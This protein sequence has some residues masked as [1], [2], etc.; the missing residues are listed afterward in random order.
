MCN[1]AVTPLLVGSDA[2]GDEVR[3]TF[4]EMKEVFEKQTFLRIT[5]DCWISPYQKYV[6]GATAHWFN[7][8]FELQEVI[9]C[10]KEIS[11]KHTGVNIA[12]HLIWVL[13]EYG[14]LEKIFCVVAH[15]TSSNGTM[16]DALEAV[17]PNFKQDQD[18]LGCVAH[19][20][21]LVAWD[22][23]KAFSQRLGKDEPVPHDL[24]SILE[25][26]Q[27]SDVNSVLTQLHKLISWIYKSPQYLQSFLKQVET[28]LG[29]A[30]N[31]V[32]NIDT[33]WKS[34]LKCYSQAYRLRVSLYQHKNVKT[35]PTTGS[36]TCQNMN[37]SL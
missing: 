35:I 30:L 22:E 25:L 15:N 37:G 27:T 20:I 3:R 19:V 7:E 13:R 10:L 2:L 5:C 8:K 6:S 14:A 28:D 32:R 17:C 1:P 26:I 34:D 4:S 36:M 31:L 16:A 33:R 11:G 9:L 23:L 18:L 29:Y 12:N 21:N 24:S